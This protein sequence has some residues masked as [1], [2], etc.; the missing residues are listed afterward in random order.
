MHRYSEQPAQQNCRSV[1][2]CCITDQTGAMEVN[3]GNNNK[4]AGTTA[5]ASNLDPCNYQAN[6]LQ[7]ITHLLPLICFQYAKVGYSYSA[8]K[9][10]KVTQIAIC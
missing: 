6:M 3:Q 4:H 9:L 5:W 8:Y 2:T 1:A 7:P 10:H